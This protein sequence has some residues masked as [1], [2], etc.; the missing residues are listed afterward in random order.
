MNH[1]NDL[2][3]DPRYQN[4]ESRPDLAGEHKWGDGL[5]LI[6]LLLFIGV[7]ILDYKFIGTPD[8][9]A[10]LIPLWIRLSASL[11]FFG[12]AGWLAFR[13]IRIVFGEYREQ[14]V[15]ITQGM[16]SVVRHP[17][18]LGALLAYLAIFFLTLSL[19]S[20]LV[21]ILAIL[22]YNWLALDE[23]A[24]MLHVFGEKYEQYQASVPMWFPRI[25]K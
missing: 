12:A 22:L 25:K 24:R 6:N 3:N 13:G 8:L 18:Y 20:I 9:I 7:T 5:Q 19:L 21:W 15:M 2:K 4:H 11:I 23:E 10:P 1:Q 16:F 14:P 17:I